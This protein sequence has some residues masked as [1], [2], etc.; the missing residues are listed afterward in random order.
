MLRRVGSL[1]APLIAAVFLATG[2]GG[3][4]ESGPS[5][6]LLVTRDFGTANVMDSKK[7]PATKGL[8]AMRQLQS[9]AEVETTYGGRFVNSIDGLKGGGGKDWLF[10]VDGVDSDKAATEIRLSGVE[11]VQWDFHPWQA[12]KLTG[13]IVGAFPEP[14]RTRGAEVA[15][16]DDESVGCQSTRKALEAAG[17][18]IDN[19]GEDAAT[20]NVGTWNDLRGRDG[21]PD[22]SGPPAESGV[23]ASFTGNELGLADASGAVV[24]SARPD[25][26]LVFAYRAGDKL[27]WVIT[28]ATE[29]GVRAAAD[30]LG[31]DTLRGR[32]AVI[33]E[34]GSTTPLPISGETQEYR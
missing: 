7:V 16:A 8:T 25:S 18:D 17:I 23:F 31:R 13:A 3:G 19:P 32:F 12:V 9:H 22:V 6:T 21:V 15:C 29:N 28:G 4:D 34:G 5:T 33:R 20:V 27:G 26:G 14:L 11:T 10:Y 1:V 30:S 24:R 2:C